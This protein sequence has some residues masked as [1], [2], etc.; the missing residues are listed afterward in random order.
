MMTSAI[1]IKVIY[2]S[3]LQEAMKRILKEKSHP[4]EI[5]N[6]SYKVIFSM[7]GHKVIFCH[8]QPN[9]VRKPLKLFQNI[10]WNYYITR[11]KLY[12]ANW[13]HLGTWRKLAMTQVNQMIWMKCNALP[14]NTWCF[15]P[16]EINH[17]HACFQ[18][19]STK[20]LYTFCSSV[21]PFI[22]VGIQQTTGLPNLMPIFTANVALVR[23]YFFPQSF[24]VGHIKVI[25][26]E[27]KVILSSWRS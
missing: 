13:T 7:L 19:T 1:V 25:F 18:Y 9:S 10:G 23:S 27:N 21:E 6:N 5:Y 16:K 4:Y 24:L 11:S 17:V 3:V 8:F 12:P 14:K 22:L 26:S 15:C 20:L 2:F